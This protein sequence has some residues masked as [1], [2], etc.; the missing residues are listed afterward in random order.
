MKMKLLDTYKSI[1]AFAGCHTTPEGQIYAKMDSSGDTMEL[2]A[3]G[4]KWVLPTEDNC[5]K[6]YAED[7]SLFHPLNENVIKPESID[8]KRLTKCL[9]TRINFST[10]TLFATLLH[11]ASD[12]S[13][14]LNLTP[15]QSEMCSVLKQV[16]T[17][18][19]TSIDNLMLLAINRKDDLYK[20]VHVHLKRGTT[21]KGAR[22]SRTGNIT[23]PFYEH[24]KDGEVCNRKVKKQEK[25]IITR[26]Y[27]Y[28]FP[29]CGVEDEYSHGSDANTAPYLEALLRACLKVVD[30]ITYVSSIFDPFIEDKYIFDYD[31]AWLLPFEDLKGYESEIRTVA[32][33]QSTSDVE[34]TA[35]GSPA[36]T[37]T[38]T[39]NGVS[40]GS[41]IQSLSQRPMAPMQNPYAGILQQQPI[42][43]VQQPGR[44][45]MSNVPTWAI[46]KPQVAPAMPYP[47]QVP[48]YNVP[49]QYPYLQQ[50]PAGYNAIQQPLPY[51]YPQQAQVYNGYPQQPVY[52][53]QIPAGYNTVQQPMP[54]PQQPMANNNM[55]LANTRVSR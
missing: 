36:P 10:Y 5:K 2:K 32:A 8:I 34:N 50:V 38:R 24:L 17:E 6:A 15:E 44:V 26:L 43:M 9:I 12:T 16:S 3:N 18:Q 23:F 4:K 7:L 19:S 47:Q 42:G 22:H 27:E 13:T 55:T 21:I 39:A 20:L 45:P 54:Y 49:V 40:A 35:T 51:P 29:N 28:V 1:L 41:L 31:N 14:H 11:V 33:T 46:G 25:E 37:V 48:G 53:Q 52:Q 30:R